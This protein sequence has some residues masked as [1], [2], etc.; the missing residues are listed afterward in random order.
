VFFDENA[1]HGIDSSL[2]FRYS[3][4][5]DTSPLRTQLPHGICLDIRK[6]KLHPQQVS[7]LKAECDG[8]PVAFLLSPSAFCTVIPSDIPPRLFQSTNLYKTELVCSC[9]PAVRP[10]T[11]DPLDRRMSGRPTDGKV[12]IRGT[13]QAETGELT[14]I[15]LSK[16]GTTDSPA[17]MF[18]T[19]LQ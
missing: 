14:S 6:D 13:P 4:H 16:S 17:A 5:L 7:S 8:S 10:A 1:S 2:S 11:L 19:I 12:H 9:V 3:A 18:K 15:L